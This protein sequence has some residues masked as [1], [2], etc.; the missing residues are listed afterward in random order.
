MHDDQ[1][2]PADPA[3][4]PHCSLILILVGLSTNTLQQSDKSL[5]VVVTPVVALVAPVYL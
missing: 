1:A 4:P 3:Y 2:I 5:P